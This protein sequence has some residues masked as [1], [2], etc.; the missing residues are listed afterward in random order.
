[1]IYKDCGWLG[2]KVVYIEK[3]IG[4]EYACMNSAA[5]SH[6]QLKQIGFPLLT[7]ATIC[8]LTGGDYISFF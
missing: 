8:I 2:R 1:M 3:T 6:P 4:V 7:L 5:M